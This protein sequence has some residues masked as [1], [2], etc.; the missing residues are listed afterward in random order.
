M[1]LIRCTAKLQKEMGLKKAQLCQLEEP[2]GLLGQWHAN[3]IFIDRKK[4]V[5]FVNDRTL[6]N[7]I[8]PDVRR[9]E[10][11]ELASIFKQWLRPVLFAEAYSSREIELIC[12]EYI[13]IAYAVSNSRKI[14]GHIKDLAF[15]YEVNIQTA[16]G[17]HSPE[18]PAI[19]KRLNRMPMNAGKECTWPYKELKK[20][21]V[22]EL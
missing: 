9:S 21:V 5:L 6:S 15:H 7:F 22:G 3:L 2:A 16:G 8:V 13:E 4:C 10:I 12:A 19:I 17:V 1:Q 20:L 18:I 14:L 11:R